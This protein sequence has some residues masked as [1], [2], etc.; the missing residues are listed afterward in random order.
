MSLEPLVVGSIKD[1]IVCSVWALGELA[2]PAALRQAVDCDS[3]IYGIAVEGLV[4]D[5]YMRVADAGH[6][7]LDDEY[8]ATL[9]PADRKPAAA[10]V[11]STP[12]HS[13]EVTPVARTKACKKCGHERAANAATFGADSRTND[14]LGK[15]CSQCKHASNSKPKARAVKQ[16]QSAPAALPIADEFVI[17]AAGQIQCRVLDAGAGKSFVIQQGDDQ[18]AC[19][20]D[21]LQ[22]LAFWIGKVS[23]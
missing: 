22:A 16:S 21:Q 5:Q 18:V 12:P 1:R 23:A 17:P 20:V 19:T 7:M 4:R 15:T 8:A 9:N 10:A 13:I 6:Y 14:G 11:P 3:A 2:T